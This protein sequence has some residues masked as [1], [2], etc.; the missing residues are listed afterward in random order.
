VEDEAVLRRLERGKQALSPAEERE[1]LG[2]S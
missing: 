1:W 2:E